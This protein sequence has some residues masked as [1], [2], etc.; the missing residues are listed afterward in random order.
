[1]KKKRSKNN[2]E[3]QNKFKNFKELEDEDLKDFKLE[4]FRKSMLNELKEHE[5]KD[6]KAYIEESKFQRD[7]EDIKLELNSDETCKNTIKDLASIG[8]DGEKTL[9]LL[10]LMKKGLIN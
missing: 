2:E 8:I 5:L 1:M 9:K 4:D 7:T 6:F 10:K 3:S